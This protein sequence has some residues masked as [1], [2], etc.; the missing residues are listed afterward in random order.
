MTIHKDEIL[1]RLAARGNVAQFV[2]FAP[3]QNRS[4][5]Q[6]FSRLVGHEANE[7]FPDIEAAI[8]VLFN[9]SS[10]GTINIRSY[11]PEDPRSREFLYALTSVESACSAVKRLSL[12]G[13]HTIVNET[14]DVSD[15]GVSG[16]VQGDIIEFSPDDT[17]RCVEKP[18]VLSMPFDLGMALLEKVY[19]FRPE[20]EGSANERTEFSI[21]PNACGWKGSHTL[22]WEHEEDVVSPAKQ[23]IRWP[24]N[25]SRHLGDKTF[26]LLVADRLGFPVP[27]TLVIPR[28]LAPFSFGTA[29]GSGEIWTRTCPFEP[30]PGLFTTVKGWIDPFT[31]LATE[32]PTGSAI[33][34]LLKQDAVVAAWSGAAITGRDD[35]IVIEGV[36]GEGDQ[37]MLGL[38]QPAALPKEITRDVSLLHCKLSKVLGPVR[39]EWVHDGSQVWCVQLHVGITQSSGSVI[40]PGEASDWREVS[41]SDGLEAIR[42]LLASLPDGCGVLVNGHVGVTSH[43]ADLLRKKGSPARLV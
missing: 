36:P 22:L 41:A 24:N 23:P 42:N 8:E 4:P 27:S 2:S 14:I 9:R 13:L 30:Q 26:G 3:D 6:T 37:L 38:H 1:N 12:E 33:A 5:Q 16:V 15:G 11:L 21:H 32:D 31:L 43:I 29:T 25:F 17:P 19:G 28:K 34:S 20:L 10:A 40:V 7:V 35:E 39:I 18:G